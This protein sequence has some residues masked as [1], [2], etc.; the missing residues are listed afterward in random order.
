MYKL[1]LFVTFFILLSSCNEQPSIPQKQYLYFENGK[2]RREY[3]VIN[4]KKEGLMVDFY[5]D[6]KI[7]S[8]RFFRNDV[9]TGKTVVYHLNGAIKEVQYFD[10]LAQREKG[11]TVWYDN[12]IF[13]YI[14]QFAHGRKNG[15]MTKYDSSGTI[16]YKAQFKDDSLLN[17]LE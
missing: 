10:S 9:Q 13:E 8:E 12:G 4:E 5:L 7:K 14:A 6:G 3:Q 1:I 11:D 2:T 16:I 17:V 15:L